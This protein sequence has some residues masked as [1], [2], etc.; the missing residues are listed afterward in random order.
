MNA[1]LPINRQTFLGGSDV[2]AILGVAPSTWKDRC[3]PLDVYLIK[4][5]QRVIETTDDLQDLFDWGKKLEPVVIDRLRKK[6]GVR[7]VKRSTPRK[8][9]RYVDAEYPFLAA[10]IDFEWRV[11]KNIVE[12]YD[13]D[14][15]L[16][17]TIQNG[18]IKTVH[19]FASGKFGDEGDA[20]PIEYAAQAQH[21][22]MV[23][24]P[25]RK[26][27][28]FG[29]LQGA[30]RSVDLYFLPRGDKIIG[31]MR[32][33]LVAFWNDHVLA[34]VPPEAIR[35]EDVQYLLGHK[36]PASTTEAS[37]EIL[38]LLPDLQAARDAKKA[39]EDRE[40]EVK[41]QIGKFMLGEHQVELRNGGKI[42]PL[43]VT[44]GHHLLTH[45]GA[46]ILDV[47]MQQQT[48]L[49]GDRLKAERPE[50]VAE[51][52]KQTSFLKFAKPPKGKRK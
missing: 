6:H 8:P 25:D 35:I 3:T 48:R 2:A 24:G 5:G 34:G 38:A 30:N 12:Q 15:A 1:P 33:R 47:H 32:R 22:M 45:G 19:A 31:T 14:P 46:T 29:V 26:L 43:G 23:R 39:A 51:F 49:D 40:V 37:E 16:I 41:Y 9:N 21:G 42:V 10:E 7:I 52:S 28:L 17:G 18:E 27:C 13:L 44:P 20:V 4:T 50:I 11:T 36:L